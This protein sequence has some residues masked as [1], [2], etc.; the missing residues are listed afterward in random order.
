MKTSIY[1]GKN[2]GQL[3]YNYM[4]TMR[5]YNKY[6][7][8]FSYE[9]EVKNMFT[10]MNEIQILTYCE[11]KGAEHS[12][13]H[14]HLLLKVENTAMFKRSLISYV[15][16]VRKEFGEKEVLLKVPKDE[17]DKKSDVKFKDVK[18]IIEYEKYFGKKLELYVERI[19][20]PTNA[21][22]YAFKFC[23]YGLR[24]ETLFR[25]FDNKFKR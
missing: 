6:Y 15:Q 25:D 11:E 3:N 12:Y 7:E 16:P 8:V 24:T 20:D 5:L 4:A 23:D 10:K 21:S 1:L 19:I 14:A 17:N 13:M 9:Q 18:T 2:A 22:I